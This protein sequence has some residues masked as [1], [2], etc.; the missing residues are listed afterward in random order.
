MPKAYKYRIYPNSKQR[1]LFEKT[2]GCVKFYWNK[3]LEI[4]LSVFRENIGK[5]KGERKS[6]P[7]VL[8]FSVKREYPFL[9]EVDSLALAN[10]QLNLE[11]TF[12]LFLSKNKHAKVQ[13]KVKTKLYNE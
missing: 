13:K 11:K 7:Q 8:S 3:A 1:E 9:R 4:R 2:F 12:K 6:I 5:P 10:A